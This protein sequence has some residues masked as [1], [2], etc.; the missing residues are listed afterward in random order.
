M[1]N[2]YIFL[3]LY[4]FVLHVSRS[5][6]RD[7]PGRLL[8]AAV[9]DLDPGAYR[10]GRRGVCRVGGRPARVVLRQGRLVHAGRGAA[11]AG[12]GGGS[13]GGGTGGG[14]GGEEA[15]VSTAQEQHGGED[16]AKVGR[17]AK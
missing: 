3:S 1:I 6:I 14:G 2:S 4:V 12:Q 11:G 13:C 15:V 16:G 8:Q 10:P 5:A 17:V 7:V 9:G